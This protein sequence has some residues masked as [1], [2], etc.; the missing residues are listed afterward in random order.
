MSEFRF[1]KADQ[2]RLVAVK[3][4][5]VPEWLYRIYSYLPSWLNPKY[6]AIARRRIT[7]DAPLFAEVS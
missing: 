4:D 2:W 7:G 5:W 3:R 6:A 1:P